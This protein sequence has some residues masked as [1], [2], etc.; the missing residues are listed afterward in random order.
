MAPGQQEK[1]WRRWRLLL[2][3]LLLLLPLPQPCSLCQPHI[4]EPEIRS[5]S[6]AESSH[7]LTDSLAAQK[8]RGR[9]DDIL[10]F[11]CY[12]YVETSLLCQAQIIYVVRSSHTNS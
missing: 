9:L 8:M 12:F 3:L 6:G 5:S 2:L 1:H 11:N 7:G 10:N 4:S